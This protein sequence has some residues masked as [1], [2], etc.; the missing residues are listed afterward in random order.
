MTFGTRCDTSLA[1]A[2][3][4][5][6]RRPFTALRMSDGTKMEKPVTLHTLN[7]PYHPRAAA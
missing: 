3:A 7:A 6:N 4:I 5:I 1:I 2:D